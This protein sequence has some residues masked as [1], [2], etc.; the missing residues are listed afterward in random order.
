[1]KKTLKPILTY[2]R[3]IISALVMGLS[4]TAF[5]NEGSSTENEFQ[6]RIIK[7][8]FIV[9]GSAW[10]GTYS[11]DTNL[12][13]KWSISPALSYFVVDR[14]SVGGFV[15]FFNTSSDD[16]IALVGAKANWHFLQLGHWV[17]DTGVYG[18]A[19]L[20]DSSILAKF[21]GTLTTQYYFTDSAAIGPS[22]LVGNSVLRNGNSR[23][24]YEFAIATSL[25]I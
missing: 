25:S 3:P 16:I 4:L 6:P 8:N 19:G 15:S 23:Q 12:P 7:G 1:M 13:T 5:A 11:G 17:F 2:F 22:V 14:I 24:Y 9:G 20:T 18:G 10:V 21:G